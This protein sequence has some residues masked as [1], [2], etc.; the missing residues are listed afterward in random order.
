[1]KNTYYF[2]SWPFIKFLISLFFL[3]PSL[4]PPLVDFPRWDKSRNLCMYKYSKSPNPRPLFPYYRLTSLTEYHP[5]YGFFSTSTSNK[6]DKYVQ[7]SRDG[8]TP[9]VPCN[10]DLRAKSLG[11]S[12]ITGDHGWALLKIDFFRV[13]SFISDFLSRR[14]KF[15]TPKKIDMVLADTSEAA[16]VRIA[17]RNSQRE[18]KAGSDSRGEGSSI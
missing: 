14:L 16:Y 12:S 4:P 7:R 6:I 3:P 11:D 13:I 1:M 15:L 10:T 9:R 2:C 8:G 18:E 5:T 17:P